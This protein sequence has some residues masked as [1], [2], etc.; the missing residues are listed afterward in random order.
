M[1]AE[2]KV[3][4]PYDNRVVAT[5]P[6]FTERE[7]RAAVGRAA[8]S[9]VGDLP[10]RERAGFLYRAGALIEEHI[11]SLAK[12]IVRESGKPVR[13]ARREVAQAAEV[14]TLAAGEANRLTGETLD[15]PWQLGNVAAIPAGVTA[16]FVPYNYPLA[17]VARY[18]APAL[19]AGC[20]V[21]VKPELP[22]TA[23]RMLD[24]LENAGLP[25][26]AFEVVL[27]DD[28]VNEWLLA[29]PRVAQ[30]AVVGSPGMAESIARRAG[31]RRTLLDVQSQAI[32]IVDA[33]ADLPRAATVCASSAFAF[34]GQLDTC[35]RRIHVHRSVYDE[36]R[37]RF[38]DAAGELVSGNPMQEDTDLGPLRSDDAAQQVIDQVNGAI[39]EGA[40]LLAGGERDGR[41]VAPLVLENLD[42]A[43]QIMQ[44]P[45]VGPVAC[46]SPFDKI[47]DALRLVNCPTTLMS[48][49]T[50]DLNLAVRVAQCLD[51]AGVAINDAP[52]RHESPQ[53]VRRRMDS[54]THLR[55]VIMASAE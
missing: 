2:I 10:A 9:T 29:D 4:N 36:F 11:D 18:T 49:F 30:A 3:T 25:S 31:L 17:D 22:L 37:F 51:A 32:A 5:V 24:L 26:G 34:G 45:V 16:V 13:L 54:M 40:W 50:R 21:V 52:T 15:L 23:L 1:A 53:Q 35:L 43:M 14:F 12:L 48:L 41:M 19:A 27:G 28:A 33:E 38:L 39:E 46:L 6:M 42:D 7:V 55:T 8:D 47:D 44:E 20:T